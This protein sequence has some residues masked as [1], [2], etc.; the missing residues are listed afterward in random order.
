MDRKWFEI[1]IPAPAQAVDLICHEM[2]ELGSEGITVEERPLDTFVMPDPD[3]HTPDNY[4]LKARRS[5]RQK[6]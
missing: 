6:N 2:V 5:R 1:I 3:A 4:R